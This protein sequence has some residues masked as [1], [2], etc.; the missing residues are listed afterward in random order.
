[1]KKHAFYFRAFLLLMLAVM[2]AGCSKK[3]PTGPAI[4]ADLPLSGSMAYY[5]QEVRRGM[6]LAHAEDPSIPI[7]FEDNHSN[8]RDAVTVFTKFVSDENIPVVV[9]ANSPLSA[10]L[11]PLASE[12]KIVLLALVTGMSNFPGENPWVFRDSIT[13]TIE[14]PPLASYAIEKLQAKRAATLVV[15]DDYGLDGAATFTSAFQKLGGTVV[16]K[17]TFETGTRAAAFGAGAG[18][19]LRP[20]RSLQPAATG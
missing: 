7:D 8:A 3:A 20:G 18:L 19:H 15:N 6:E 2:G 17:D 12:N 11:R 1:M 14:S 13:Q 10:P 5:G 16:A 4:G 9:S